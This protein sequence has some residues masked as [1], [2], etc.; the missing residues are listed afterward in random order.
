[1]SNDN[2]SNVTRDHP[3]AEPPGGGRTDQESMRKAAHLKVQGPASRDTLAAGGGLDVPGGESHAGPSAQHAGLGE[4]LGDAGA[5]IPGAREADTLTH[6]EPGAI[7]GVFTGGD[8]P[9]T[10][11]EWLDGR[12]SLEHAREGGLGRHSGKDD[13]REQRRNHG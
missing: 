9:E 12:T 13:A 6:R 8:I 10:A 1:M 3:Q 2:R 7:G 5:L 11:A 4:A